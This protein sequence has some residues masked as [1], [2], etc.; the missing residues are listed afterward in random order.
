[1]PRLTEIMNVDVLRCASMGL[2]PQQKSTGQMT[3]PGSI[4]PPQGNAGPSQRSFQNDQSDFQDQANPTA[5]QPQQA[6]E[7]TA[8]P[9]VKLLT[10]LGY[11]YQGTDQELGGMPIGHTFVGQDGDM[12]MVKPD[13]SWKRFGPGA[14]QSQGPD[15][16]SLGQGLVRD[17]L[18]QGDDQNPHSALRQAGYS[19]IHQDQ[20]GN[21][22]YKHPQSGNSVTVN[23]AGN[24]QSSVGSGKGANK[25]RDFLGNEQMQQQDPNI[26]KA[27]MQQQQ[28]KQ[29]QQMS[30]QQGLGKPPGTRGQGSTRGGQQGGCGMQPRPGGLGG[31]GGF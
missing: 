31:R 3:K 2:K 23:K 12:I 5:Q 29:K 16:Q 28:M 22:Y 26:Q 18:Q 8:A 11:E 30:Q 25:L 1:M 19:K 10:K 21:T 15:V 4:A 9:Y 13:G 20:Q 27:K 17:S 7:L 14:Q 24:W 6:P